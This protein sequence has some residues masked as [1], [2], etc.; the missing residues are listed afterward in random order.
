MTSEPEY[1]QHLV[2]LNAK[3]LT[4]TEWSEEE[5]MKLR[6]IQLFAQE[7]DVSEQMA[8]KSKLNHQ[9]I[10]VYPPEVFEKVTRTLMQEFPKQARPY[11]DIL[12]LAEP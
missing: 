1:K 7:V 11:E 12:L 9:A 6:G 3:W 8:D 2:T 10:N 4:L 5:R